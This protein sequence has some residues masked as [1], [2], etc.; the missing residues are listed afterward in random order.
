MWYQNV[1]LAK[2]CFRLNV[3]TAITLV[4]DCERQRMVRNVHQSDWFG[5]IF[6]FLYFILLGI[7]PKVKYQQC[8]PKKNEYRST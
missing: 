7:C 4:M 1:T 2:I 8:L 6:F 5:L 3:L